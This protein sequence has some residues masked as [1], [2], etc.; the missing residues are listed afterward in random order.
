MQGV[1][2]KNE[3]RKRTRVPLQLSVTVIARNEEIS[4]R[5]RD[6]SLRGLGCTPDRRCKPGSPCTVH[7]IL[8]S[9]TE[10]FIEGRIVRCSNTGAAIFFESMDEDA[11]YHLKRLIQFNLD[12]PDILDTEFAEQG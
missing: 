11:F 2:M 8:N 7:C 9:G 10:F 1:S 3:Q 5:T 4:V 6:L 12:D